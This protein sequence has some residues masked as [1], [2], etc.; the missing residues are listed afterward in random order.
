MT[1]RATE[2]FC[3]RHGRT[4]EPANVDAK[5]DPNEPDWDKL[6]IKT[7]IALKQSR[8]IGGTMRILHVSASDGTGGAARAAFRIHRALATVESDT[9]MQSMMLVKESSQVDETVLSFKSSFGSRYVRR[10]S[11]VAHRIE[12]SLLQTGNDVLHSTAWQRTPALRQI[13]DLSPNAVFLHWLGNSTLSV[14][15]VGR[16]LRSGV[17]VY[18]FLHDTWAFCGAEHYPNGPSDWRFAEGYA[19]SNRPKWE[20]GL[21]LN[22]ITW[23]RKRRHWTVP[24]IQIA[25]SRWMANL[26]NASRLT[27]H[28]PTFTVGNP[29]D[30]AW[31]GAHSREGAR[32]ELGIAPHRRMV[33]FGAHGGD[34][35]PRKGADLLQASLRS[36]VDRALASR[37]VAPDI[38]M[39]G[40]SRG[41]RAIDGVQVESVGRLDD[42]ALRRFYSAADVMVVPSRQE[43]FGQ[44]ASEALACGTPVVAFSVGGLT[45]IVEDR[46]N[47][48]LVTPFNV[49]ELSDAI[50]WC[51]LSDEALRRRLSYEA[52]SSAR[53]WS[54]EVIGTKLAGIVSS[55]RKPR[56]K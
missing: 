36:V 23:N 25:P 18:W 5:A 42:A 48:R 47:G 45:D 13:L 43:S 39:F 1:R 6:F 8:T 34:A 20:A 33:L 55:T 9:G 3:G 40:G 54:F 10:L 35:D 21:D 19:R 37:G 29:I 46:V 27:G 16:L 41:S 50:A 15:Q 28:L 56:S 24:F 4:L 31:W 53:K 26:A 52:K 12:R 44:T 38:V 51:I 7:A 11:R 22:R 32:K 14:E 49:E 17:P 30:T 2:I